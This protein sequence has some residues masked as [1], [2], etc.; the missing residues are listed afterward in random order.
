VRMRR[1][2]MREALPDELDLV[3]RAVGHGYQ[4]AVDRADEKT[5]PP[6]SHGADPGGRP[7][8]QIEQAAQRHS[9][10]PAYGPRESLESAP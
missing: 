6:G 10:R 5:P 8:Q 1:S 3:R 7:A 9:P 2:G 4:R